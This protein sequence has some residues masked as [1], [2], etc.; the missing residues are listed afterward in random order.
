MEM[1]LTMYTR[2]FFGSYTPALTE[3]NKGLAIT[4]L[5]VVDE[6]ALDVLF[7]SE[8]HYNHYTPFKITEMSNYPWTAGAKITKLTLMRPSKSS[9]L[10][11]SSWLRRPVKQLEPAGVSAP[12]PMH[13]SKYFYIVLEGHKLIYQKVRMPCWVRLCPEQRTSHLPPERRP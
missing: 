2:D 10:G 9:K 6:K 5:S 3:G 11:G 12:K 1:G 4:T 7:R 8:W 13:M